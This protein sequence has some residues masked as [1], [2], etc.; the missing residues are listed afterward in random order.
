MVDHRFDTASDEQLERGMSG[1][2]LLFVA[3]CWLVVAAMI[4]RRATRRFKSLAA[5]IAIG[6]LIFPL[7]LMAPVADEIVGARQFDA[8]CK[9][10]AVQVIDEEHALNRRVLSVGRAGERFVEGTAVRIRIQPWIY[11]DAETDKLLVS[12]HTLHATGGWLIRTLGI[13]ETN[14][15]LLFRRGCGPP[16]QDAFKKKFNITVIN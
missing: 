10:Y 13:S 7:L 9:Q 5:K 4:T 3:A 6:T 12:Y 16:D 1:L 15:P 2:L 14:S 8:L 11:K